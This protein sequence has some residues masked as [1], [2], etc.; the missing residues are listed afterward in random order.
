MQ[1][2]LQSSAATDGSGADRIE[3]RTVPTIAASSVVSSAPALVVANWRI[4]IMRARWT[5]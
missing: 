3:D 5:L 2:W 4:V 1:M